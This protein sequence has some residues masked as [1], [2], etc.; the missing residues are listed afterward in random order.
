M[1]A[2]SPHNT[3]KITGFPESLHNWTSTVL[4]VLIVAFRII[5]FTLK[6][7]LVSPNKYIRL[8][9]ESFWFKMELTILF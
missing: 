6:L 8:I 9:S 1:E 3:N 4:I 2:I 7:N 5:V